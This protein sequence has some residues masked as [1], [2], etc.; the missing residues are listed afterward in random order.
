[1]DGF[2]RPPDCSSPLPSSRG[3]SMLTPRR[4]ASSS[5]CGT[6]SAIFVAS[7]SREDV[8]D[9]VT[10]RLD[11]LEVF[12]LDAEADAALP[13]VLLERFRQLDQSQRVGIEV[14]G[15]RVS[16]VDGG[17]L[18]LEDVGQTV[19]DQVEDLLAVEGAALDMGLGGRCWILLVTGE[20]GRQ[21]TGADVCALVND[22]AAT[23]AA[24]SRSTMP[25]ST[26][27]P[28]TRVALTMAVAD[29]DPWLM[30]H[31]PP[32]PSSMAPPVLSGSRVP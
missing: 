17:G 20:N 19:T 12:V 28:A 8:V 4:P 10:H 18:D 5:R 3:S 31:T 29:D 16:F 9:G 32:T 14:V 2:S 1:M 23:T 24:R 6:G 13:Q 22:Q 25:A 21:C 11:V 7:K 30:M 15:E 27:S 26:I